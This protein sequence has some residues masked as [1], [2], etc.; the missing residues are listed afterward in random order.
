MRYGGR[1]GDAELRSATADLLRHGFSFGAKRP[2][3]VE[4]DLL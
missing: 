2:D 4:A 3:L 1:H